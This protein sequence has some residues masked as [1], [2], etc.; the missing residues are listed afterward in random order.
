MAARRA[1]FLVLAS[2][3]FL[4]LLPVVA[5]G[6]STKRLDSSWK[7]YRNQQWGFCV[8]YPRRWIRGDAFEGAGLFVGTGVQRYSKPVG[9]ID[10]AVVPGPAEAAPA[11]SLTLVD[12]LQIHLDGLKRFERAERMEVLEQRKI[13][14]EGNP[15]LFTRDRYY[16]PL[17][18]SSWIEEVVFA[19]H[20]E[21]LY[22]LELECR[23]D[24]LERFDVAFNHVL[25]T[26]QFDCASR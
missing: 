2:F 15:A 21:V 22:R 26:F 13:D 25:N 1:S 14:L 24:Q 6:G 12:N 20:K 19:K 16:D 17:E 9:E 23:S 11:A 3:A 18:R 10:V 5:S 4:S 8:D 7:K